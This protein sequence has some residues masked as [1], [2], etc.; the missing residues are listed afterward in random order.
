MGPLRLDHIESRRVLGWLISAWI[1]LSVLAMDPQGLSPFGPIKWL[2]VSTLLPV[3]AIMA[4]SGKVVLHKNAMLAWL[5]LIGW[6]VLAAVLGVDKFHAWFGT[7]TRRFGVHA[8]LLC[9][10]AF[11]IGHQV[12]L[13]RQGELVHKAFV[14]AGLGLGLY[15]LLEALGAAPVELTQF[16]TRLGSTYGSPAYLGAASAL[17]FPAIVGISTSFEGRWRSASYVSAAAVLFAALASGTRAAWV[18]LAAAVL[19]VIAVGRRVLALKPGLVAMGMLVAVV[20]LFVTPVGSRLVDAVDLSQG[21]SRGRLAEWGVGVDAVAQRPFSGAGPEGY[22]IVFS[23]SVSETYAQTYGREQIVDRAHNGLI[24]IAVTLGVPGAVLF[25]GLVLIIGKVVFSS[26]RSRDPVLIGTGAALLAYLVQQQFLFPIAEI[27][28]LAW[29]LAGMLVVRV[30]E[31]QEFLS[32]SQPTPAVRTLLLVGLAALAGAALVFGVLDVMASRSADKALAAASAGE[33]AEAA[34]LASDAG[35]LRPDSITYAAV[36]AEVNRLANTAPGLDAALEANSQGLRYSPRDPGLLAGRG[37]LYLA[38]ARIDQGEA[39]GTIAVQFWERLAEDDHNNGRFQLQLGAAY[40]QVREWELAESA[41]T[42]SSELSPRSVEAV[43]N[44]GLLFT[45]QGRV[46][47]ARMQ[48]AKAQAIAP[49]HAAVQQLEDA[50]SR[51]G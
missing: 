16:P 22:R 21:T 11:A 15:G 31:P 27:D 48:L 26:F 46:Q 49:Q 32:W 42:R 44:L 37:A 38:R 19:V 10:C 34:E 33:F 39:A 28:P 5:L 51:A 4:T 7:P 17:L 29:F 35:R 50:V 43:V 30:A 14:V 36:Q 45:A 47:E 1:V 25:L 9:A 3:A 18:G 40:S 20:T 13:K 2:V 23:E 6:A 12:V 24:D 8:W 41:W